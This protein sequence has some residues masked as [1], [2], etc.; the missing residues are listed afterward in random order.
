MEKLLSVKGGN[1]ISE[2]YLTT[3]IVEISVKV[4]SFEFHAFMP[5]FIHGQQRMRQALGPRRDRWGS[6]VSSCLCCSNASHSSHRYFLRQLCFLSDI[7]HHN[8]AIYRDDCTY[9]R[10]CQQSMR[11]VQKRRT[12]IQLCSFLLSL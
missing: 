2:R 12:I 4:M 1:K 11:S 5:G 10:L 9:F 8:R 6:R 7:P 3:F